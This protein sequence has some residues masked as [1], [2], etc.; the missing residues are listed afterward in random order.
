V[1][2]LEDQRPPQRGCIRRKSLV[3]GNRGG[4]ADGRDRACDLGRP[5]AV[6]D[7]ARIALCDQMGVEP[8]RQR[9]DDPGDADVPGDV[10]LK[11]VLGRRATSFPSVAFSSEVDRFA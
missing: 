4:F 5:V 6:D 3:A 2:G 9:F 1:I 8:L 10:T 7:E 11:L